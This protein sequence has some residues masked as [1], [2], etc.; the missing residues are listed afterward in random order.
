MDGF[1][2]GI[3][4]FGMAFWPAFGFGIFL[5]VAMAVITGIF[6]VRLTWHYFAIIT[7]V[8]SQIFYIVALSWKPVTGG[9]D[10]MLFALPPK[11]QLGETE[12]SLTDQTLQ[13]FFILAVEIGRAHV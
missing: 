11:L 13:Y 12:F 7:L 3:A 10:G 5:A 1:A 2:I 8:F 4:K 6:A 9:D